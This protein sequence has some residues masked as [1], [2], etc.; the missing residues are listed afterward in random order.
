MGL[1][2]PSRITNRFPTIRTNDKISPRHPRRFG[3]SLGGGVA[4]QAEVDDGVKI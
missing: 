2:L 3:G 4:M 1:F